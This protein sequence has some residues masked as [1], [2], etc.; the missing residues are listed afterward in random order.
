MVTSP[1]N[2]YN[3]SEQRHIMT[4]NAKEA[5]RDLLGTPSF[6]ERIQA[7]AKRAAAATVER[8][9]PGIAAPSPMK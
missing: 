1:F 3:A 9:T 2:G 7:T 4:E 5:M 6:A 8:L